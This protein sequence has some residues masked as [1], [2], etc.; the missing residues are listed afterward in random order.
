MIRNVKYSLVCLSLFL[1]FAVK[2]QTTHPQVTNHPLIFEKSEKKLHFQTSRV[3]GQ[4]P[5]TPDYAVVVEFKDKGWHEPVS[6]YG[7]G[8][9]L[10]VSKSSD[11]RFPTELGDLGRNDKWKKEVQESSFWTSMSEK[12]KRY[13]QT[14]GTGGFSDD[15]E[16]ISESEGYAMRTAT[17]FAVSEKDAQLMAN[18]LVEVLGKLHNENLI[19][20]Q[21][22]VERYDHLAQ[23]TKNQI[24]KLNEEL[25]K[26]KA[27]I[28]VLQAT[29]H[30][31]NPEP[32]FAEFVEMDK[33]VRV[34]GIDIAGANARMSA[35]REIEQKHGGK[36]QSLLDQKRVDL[37]I[38]M[39]GLLARKKA[40]EEDRDQAK[41]YYDRLKQVEATEST[42]KVETNKLKDYTCKIMI[43]NETLASL[44][45]NM[46]PVLVV[47][48]KAVI[49]PL[50]PPAP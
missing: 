21:K 13:I 6:C 24:N 39:A 20:T 36:N 18:A 47:G 14:S 50:Y 26:A 10:K 19:K 29:F 28:L 48:N 35:I 32:A 33:L 25:M 4:G 3:W 38:E 44:P 15:L 9:E 34:I 45:A 46:K 2:A 1:S 22:D 31:T 11:L 49:H 17:L 23:E 8:A 16:S 7:V 41:K 43:L 40:A 37:N 42:I 12:Q 5:V 30:Y 27:D